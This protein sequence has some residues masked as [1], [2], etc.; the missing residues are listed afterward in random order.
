VTLNVSARNPTTGGYITVWPSGSA[1]PTAS[2]LNPKAGSDCS[3][4]VMVKVGPDGKVMLFNYAGTVDVV[5]DVLGW[6]ST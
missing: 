2:N 5:V 1:R 6:F 3:N 4:A